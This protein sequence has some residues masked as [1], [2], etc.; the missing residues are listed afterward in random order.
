MHGQC[1]ENHYTWSKFNTA[2][3][4]QPFDSLNVLVL[5]CRHYSLWV[6][7]FT[8]VLRGCRLLLEFSESQLKCSDSSET[9]SEFTGIRAIFN[10]H[11]TFSKK[12]KLIRQTSAL[13]NCHFHL[14]KTALFSLDTLEEWMLLSYYPY[15]GSEIRT[16]INLHAQ[17]N[18]SAFSCREPDCSV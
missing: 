5:V 8:S 4:F 13:I 10:I 18:H 3:D 6:R 15:T 2:D 17:F 9:R 16:I 12:T 1:F 14:W 11:S 7:R